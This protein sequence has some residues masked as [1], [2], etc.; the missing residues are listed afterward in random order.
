[1]KARQRYKSLTGLTF[2]ITNVDASGIVMQNIKSKKLFKYS[3]VEFKQAI[4]DNK[5]SLL[6]YNS[7]SK[8]FEQTEFITNYLEERNKI[9]DAESND[10]TVV[11]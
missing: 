6:T 11:G 3:L 2:E 9:L 4:H 5:I 8:S 7:K 10:K 1:M